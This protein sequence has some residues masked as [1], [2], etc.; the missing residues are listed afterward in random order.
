MA[1]TS[2]I[3]LLPYPPSVNRLW[4]F[5]R[6]RMYRTATYTDWIDTAYR[7]LLEQIEPP[8]FADK[9]RVTIH[10]GF[11]DKRK[12]DIDNLIK[13]VL[14]LIER[15]DVVDNDFL[16]RDLRICESDDVSN[17]LMVTIELMEPDNGTND[18]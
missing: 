18:S 14:D 15:A 7:N 16:V 3:F 6:G 10:V 13:P 2:S 9:V 12:R 11:P 8:Q 17:G 4:R 1:S 5:S